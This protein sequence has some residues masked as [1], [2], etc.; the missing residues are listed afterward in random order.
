[1]SYKPGQAG[2]AEGIGLVFILVVPRIFLTALAVTVTEAAQF[3][4]I[5]IL[6]AGFYTFA[7]FSL[8][9][10]VAARLEGDLF[11]ICQQTLGKAGAW[12]VALFY[13]VVFWGNAALLLRLYAEN[14]LLTAL[15]EAKFEAVIL[16]FALAIGMLVSMGWATIMRTSYFYLPYL[17]IGLLVICTLLSPY[18]NIY[19]LIP[20][21]G[22]G[23]VQGLK[24]SILSAGYD[25]GVLTLIIFKPSFQSLRTVRA[26]AFYGLVLSVGLKMFYTIAYI[27]T[28]GT[29]V[30]SEKSMPF[31]E[32]ARLIYLSRYL[33][34][35]EALFILLWVIAGML[36]AAA[37]LYVALYLLVRLLDLPAL[38]PIVPLAVATTLSLAALPGSFED[39]VEIDLLFTNISLA[40]L[41]ILP[42]ILFTVTLYNLRKKAC[43]RG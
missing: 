39:V 3:S 42:P 20:W 38:R 17:L 32:M 35:I 15:P 41:F 26:A 16:W 8:L 21:Q 22:T 12:L 37:S 43:T 4:W 5:S 40:G 7:A 6:L 24:A 23:L 34:H 9:L 11:A 30:G 2:L 10:F 1:M 27:L 19:R 28:F 31:F 14:A 29:I 36:A 13:L 25:A 33:Q 18:Y